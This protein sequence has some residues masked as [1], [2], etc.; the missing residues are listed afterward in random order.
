VISRVSVLAELRCAIPGAPSPRHA[1]AIWRGCL[2]ALLS[3]FGG[4]LLAAEPTPTGDAWVTNHVVF[5]PALARLEARQAGFESLHAE[6]VDGY[7]LLVLWH[8]GIMDTNAQ[9]TLFTSADELGHWPARDWRSHP[10]FFSGPA[11]EARPPV[12]DIQVPLVYFLRVVNSASTN[13]SAMRLCRPDAAGLVMPTRL[14]WHFLEGFEQNVEGWALVTDK[15]ETDNLRTNSPGRSGYASLTV[16]LPAGRN[17]VTLGTTR[18]RGWQ[19]TGRH[20]TGIR[21]WLRTRTGRGR[22][23]FTLHTNA[24]TPGQSVVPSTIQA[25]LTDQWEKVDLPLG[26]FPK[27]RPDDV[28]WFTL[29]FIGQGPEDFLVDDLQLLGPWRSLGD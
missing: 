19:F 27:L 14:A 17:S 22:A 23:K 24:F 26:S 29:E 13:L 28:D 2:A 25:E 12:D 15:L 9:V 18:V 21:V 1:A 10:M 4:G 8:P 11:W 6:V 16:H 7:R 3:L 5:P 20:A